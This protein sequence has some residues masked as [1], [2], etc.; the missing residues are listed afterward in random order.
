MLM[1]SN[2]YIKTESNL[3]T[4]LRKFDKNQGISKNNHINNANYEISNSNAFT[5]N[6]NQMSNLLKSNNS[7]TFDNLKEKENLMHKNLEIKSENSLNIISNKNS[8]KEEISENINYISN[9]SMSNISGEKVYS[10]R[11]KS[12]ENPNK[13]SISSSNSKNIKFNNININKSE[14]T[15]EEESNLNINNKSNISKRNILP[16]QKSLLTNNS[17]IPDEYGDLQ[18]NNNK[19]KISEE[20]FDDYGQFDYDYNTSNSKVIP[21]LSNF[22]DEEIIEE[23]FNWKD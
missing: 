13:K 19:A 10:N 6:T 16:N 5:I 15:I 8:L 7:N 12:K 2:N 4:H 11:K 9:K 20:N 23:D 21:S 14:I 3:D 1:S 17:N 18:K 22:I